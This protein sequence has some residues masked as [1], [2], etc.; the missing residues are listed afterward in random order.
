[1]FRLRPV[2]SAHSPVIKLDATRVLGDCEQ[3]SVSHAAQLPVPLTVAF[4]TQVQRVKAF[5]QLEAWC[6]ASPLNFFV[7]HLGLRREAAFPASGPGG[8]LGTEGV[9]S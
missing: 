8:Q 6:P 7:G 4:R 2:G 5:C 1:M 3:L 9:V